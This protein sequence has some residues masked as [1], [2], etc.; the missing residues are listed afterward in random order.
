MVAVL[1]ET[2]ALGSAV[3]AVTPDLDEV[4]SGLLVLGWV[5]AAV[6]SVVALVRRR[7]VR[8]D[9]SLLLLAVAT[10]A[11]AGAIL[12]GR[13]ALGEAIEWTWVVLFVLGV[14]V[15]V[16]G[17]LARPGRTHGGSGPAHG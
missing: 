5:L 2:G 1:A 15:L 17:R 10:V 7:R 9:R 14:A 8:I 4:V 3:G 12:L 6:A 16:A 11:C 13:V